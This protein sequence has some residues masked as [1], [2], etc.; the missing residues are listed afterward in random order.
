MRLSLARLEMHAQLAVRARE[1]GDE[2]RCAAAARGVCG[3]PVEIGAPRLGCKRVG[4]GLGMGLGLGLGF[5][6]SASAA[7]LR[8]SFFGSSRA[9]SSP[10]TLG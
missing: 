7:A 8:T 1:G 4:L 10:P 5:R 2:L 6:L 9:A 3:R